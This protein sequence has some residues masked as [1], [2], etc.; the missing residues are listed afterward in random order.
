MACDKYLSKHFT[1]THEVQECLE[2]Q[3]EMDLHTHLAN[4]KKNPGHKKFVPKNQLHVEHFPSGYRERQIS[5]LT[6]ALA[7]LTVRIAVKFTSPDRP[8]FVPGTKDTY[9]SYNI[10]GQNLLRTGTGIVWDV[11]KYT[12]GEDGRTCQCPECFKS[13]TPRKVL[14]EVGVQTATHVVFDESE[15]RQSSCRLWFDEENCPKVNTYGWKVVMKD[16][17]RDVCELWCVTHD[18]AVAT[19]LK[20]M[21]RRFNELH[22]QVCEKYKSRRDVDKLTIIVSHPH[23]CSKQISVGHWLRGQVMSGYQTSYTYTTCTC[24]GSSGAL[25]YRLGCGRSKHPH[26]GV[27]N[28]GDNYSGVMLD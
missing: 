17:E 26:R 28:D 1:G 13:A 15:A 11:R 4:C 27:N 12:E 8:E 25:V 7:D 5:N 6:K 23:G 22:D 20:K 3:A 24:P 18:E 21:V 9:P 10:R 19:K 16:T 2:G 14:W